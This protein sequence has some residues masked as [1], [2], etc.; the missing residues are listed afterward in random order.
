M[1]RGRWKES[2]EAFERGVPAAPAN[3][4][5]YDAYAARCEGEGQWGIGV[6]VRE[7][8]LKVKSDPAAHG[9]AARAWLSLDAHDRALAQASQARRTDPASA[10]WP[11]LQ[12]EILRA[13]GDLEGSLAAWMEAIRL[14]PKDP[15]P[16]LK[17]ASLYEAMRLHGE[18]AL[19]YREVLRLR[20][21]DVEATQGLART[22]Q[23]PGR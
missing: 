14:A 1:G 5:I 12:G 7:R 11:A 9:R 10:E 21:G 17:R 16:R 2:Q 15:G 6:V 4:A 22:L 23:S 3:S 13:K 19:D 18:A 20:P 8:R